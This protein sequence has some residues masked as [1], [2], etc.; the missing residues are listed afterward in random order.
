MK[1]GS[2][3]FFLDNKIDITITVQLVIKSSQGLDYVKAACMGRL[4]STSY[5][6]REM[7][8]IQRAWK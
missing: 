7:W 5:L 3:I 2:A 6:D 1:I 4:I 8:I